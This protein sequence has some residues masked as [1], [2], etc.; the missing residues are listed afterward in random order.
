M[1][2]CLITSK[3]GYKIIISQGL[4]C[5]RYRACVPYAYMHRFLMKASQIFSDG[6]YCKES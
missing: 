3:N 6:Y 1:S 5:A 2:G 4:D